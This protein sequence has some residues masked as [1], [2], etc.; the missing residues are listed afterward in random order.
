TY[1]VGP[2]PAKVHL[3]LVSSWD[4]HPVLD[5]IARLPGAVVPDEWVIRGNHHDAWVNG[6]VDPISGLV[7]EL[8]WARAPGELAKAGWR[9]RRTIIYAAWDGEEP[10]L[11]G[12]TEWV[13][14][15][16]D[17]LRRNAVAYINSDTNM[18]GTLGMGGTPPLERLINGVARDVEDPETKLS[19]W[20]RRHLSEIVKGSTEERAE[21]R[22]RTDLRVGPLGSG[23]DFTPFAAFAGVASLSLGF[24]GEDDYG[25]YH[26]IYDDP[27]WFMKNA[28]GDFHYG[29]AL[30]QVVAIAVMRLA[31]A[32]LVPFRY[33]AQVDAF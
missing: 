29:R 12:S 24:N 16:A 1:R 10:G 2:G 17:E 14:A 8:E 33:G 13:E 11:I 32:E 26:S 19:V 25:V 7:A 27:S 23:S 9:P 5:V 30:A 20:K 22:K 18:R 3:K 28:D 31:D 21:L 15:H 4:Q 6:A